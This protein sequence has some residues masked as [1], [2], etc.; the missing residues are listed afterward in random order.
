[1]AFRKWPF[2]KVDFVKK[3][4]L[5]KVL[6]SKR[7]LGVF[8]SWGISKSKCIRKSR[9]F[10]CL[11]LAVTMPRNVLI[12]T[13]TNTQESYDVNLAYVR[14][15]VDIIGGLFSMPFARRQYHYHGRRAIIQLIHMLWEH[16]NMGDVM[17]M[18]A[19]QEWYVYQNNYHRD[20]A[21]SATIHTRVSAMPSQWMKAI[22][23]P[24]SRGYEFYKSFWNFR[25]EPLFLV[26]QNCLNYADY[27]TLALVSHVGVHEWLWPCVVVRGPAAFFVVMDLI[28][29]THG[30]DYPVPWS[31]AGELISLYNR[32]QPVNRL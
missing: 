28:R 21:N 2:L 30:T 9:A 6:L 18:G 32:W 1:M 4:I 12:L 16:V 25:C 24:M 14:G 27:E 15:V 5:A 10:S 22:V 17:T 29:R 26:A 7:H 23:E 11:Y 8:Y 13:S 19:W 31:F 20:P 3:L